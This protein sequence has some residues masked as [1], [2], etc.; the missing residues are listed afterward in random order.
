M[1]VERGWWWTT[2]FS[3]KSAP[4]VGGMMPNTGSLARGLVSSGAAVA[5]LGDKN[6]AMPRVSP[7]PMK[8]GI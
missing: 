4:G 5:S 6:A 8:A 7:N 3:A 1:I 2:S